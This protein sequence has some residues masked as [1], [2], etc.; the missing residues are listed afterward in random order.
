MNQVTLR[1]KGMS[2]QHCVNS[3]EGSVK[4]LT[5]VSKVKV[6]LQESQVFVEFHSQEVKLDQIREM[7][8]SQ[9]YDV[10]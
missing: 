4:K 3:I 7:I 8:V 9:G 1:V 10:C 5:G 6:N 2:C